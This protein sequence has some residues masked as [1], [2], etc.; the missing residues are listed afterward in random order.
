LQNE[1]NNNIFRE[2][3][4]MKESR[5][6]EFKE[7]IQSN[8]FLKTVSAFANYGTGRI[9]FGINDDGLVKGIKNAIDFCLSIE[10]KMNDNMNTVP[11]YDLNINDDSTI[12]LTYCL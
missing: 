10:N 9:I 11:L 4:V 5:N 8:T 1:W 12:T 7:T 2:E 3:T 6:L